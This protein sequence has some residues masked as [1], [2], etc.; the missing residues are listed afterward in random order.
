MG[1]LWPLAAPF[2]AH[3]EVV[4]GPLVVL[5]ELDLHVLGLDEL[6]V[7]LVVHLLQG[8]EVLQQLLA[9]LFVLIRDQFLLVQLNSESDK[10][11]SYMMHI[12][13]CLSPLCVCCCGVQ[14][15]LN[16][17]QVPLAPAK[18]I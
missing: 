3:L 18:I 6:H 12:F 16:P 10:Y 4:C 17:V 5:L 2:S 14:F 7:G 13:L 1:T 11:S 8:S 15:S 9:V